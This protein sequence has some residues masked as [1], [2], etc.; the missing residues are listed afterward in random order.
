ML[1]VSRTTRSLILPQALSQRTAIS[2]YFN[3]EISW[4]GTSPS[5]QL[6]FQSVVRLRHSLSLV[7]L[8][9]QAG[10]SLL[11]SLHC[12]Q[13]QRIFSNTFRGISPSTL[14]VTTVL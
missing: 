6:S 9:A 11:H 3:R 13:H 7:L 1:A 2:A 8:R 5:R 10:L 4:I 12:P 14:L